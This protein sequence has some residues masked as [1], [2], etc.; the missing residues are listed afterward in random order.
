MLIIQRYFFN[1]LETIINN[2]IY[3][4]G[5]TDSTAGICAAG[6]VTQDTIDIEHDIDINSLLNRINSPFYKRFAFSI[7]GWVKSIFSLWRYIYF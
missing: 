3:A 5:D 4:G 7:I 2:S 6:S 1:D